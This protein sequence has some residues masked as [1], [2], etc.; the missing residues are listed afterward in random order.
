MPCDIYDGRYGP[1]QVQ[2]TVKNG[3]LTSV[4]AIEYPTGTSRDEQI[5]AFAIPQLTQEALAAGSAKIDAVSGVGY[6][7]QG[8]ITSLQSA[9]DKAGI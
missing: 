7:S 1:V 3:N 2:I 9:L 8:Y 6:T 5:N 4:D